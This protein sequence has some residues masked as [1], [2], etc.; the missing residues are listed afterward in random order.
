MSEPH[1]EAYGATK[2]GIIAL[3]HALARSLGP[4][5]IT[6]NYL[7][8]GWIKT[9]DYENLSPID[10]EQHLSGRVGIPKD[11]VQDGGMTKKMMYEE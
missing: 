3:T 11:I 9:R 2:G 10:H 4:D 5:G 1:T 7:L 8:P 6:V